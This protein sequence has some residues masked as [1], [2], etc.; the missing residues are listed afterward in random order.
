[1][2][3]AHG[4]FHNIDSILTMILLEP[5]EKQVIENHFFIVFDNMIS[6]RN[7]KVIME[8]VMP[9]LKKALEKAKG[10]MGQSSE[11]LPILLNLADDVCS[12]DFALAL[13]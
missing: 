4:I 8:K 7:F 5:Y 2:E 3:D 10:K 11:V 6:T 9:R 13:P 12:S 1:M